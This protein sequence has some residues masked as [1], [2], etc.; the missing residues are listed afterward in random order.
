VKEKTFSFSAKD[1]SKVD[2]GPI[3]FLAKNNGVFY[4]LIFENIHLKVIEEY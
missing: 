3:S 2:V 4:K 1:L